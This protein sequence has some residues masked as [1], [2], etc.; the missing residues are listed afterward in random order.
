M[1]ISFS[2]AFQL[3]HKDSSYE[4][5]PYAGLAI[6]QSVTAT[7]TQDPEEDL[8]FGIDPDVIYSPMLVEQDAISTAVGQFME[9]A[10]ITPTQT[11]AR[12]V[13]FQNYAT[14]SGVETTA[15]DP[16]KP[17]WIIGVL[18]PGLMESD[19]AL[20][21]FNDRTD[22]PVEG[23]YYAY[24]AQSGLIVEAGSLH[25]QS[26]TSEL[27]LTQVVSETIPITPLTEIPTLEPAPTEM[28]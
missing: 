22:Q 8:L 20:M 9:T 10:A 16:T 13:S 11:I 7:P 21:F 19:T 1:I 27:S 18:A 28:W 15:A 24:S 4:Q 25:S 2:V 23:A 14:W 6:A 5:P 12:L 26:L 3:A 17:V